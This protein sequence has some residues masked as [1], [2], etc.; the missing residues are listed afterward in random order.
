M[1]A[2]VLAEHAG[3]PIDLAR[4]V[5]MLL[6]HDIVEI[7]AGDTFIYDEAARR[8]QVERE[9]RAAERLFGMLPD[10]Q[11]GQLSCWGWPGAHR[12]SAGSHSRALPTPR[13]G[14]R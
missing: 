6:I 4:V 3:A 14:D 5:K 9:G 8:T 1:M 13:Q 2:I 7:D 12:G 10:D 11:A